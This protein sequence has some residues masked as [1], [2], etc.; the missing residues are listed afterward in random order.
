M[1]WWDNYPDAW[2]ATRSNLIEP[3]DGITNYFNWLSG[4]P[5]RLVFV[6]YPAAFDFMFVYWYLINFVGKSP[7]AHSALD[8]KSYAMATFKTEYRKSSKVNIE[9]YLKISTN[10]THLALED[11]IQQGKLFCSLLKYNEY[12]SP[13]N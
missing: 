11:A 4:L 3:V 9:K 1:E 2:L 12:Q 6:G 8:I 13:E 5:G 7:F 10:H